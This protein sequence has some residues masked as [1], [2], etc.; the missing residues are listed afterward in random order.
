MRCFW[1]KEGKSFR[2]RSVYE[3]KSYIFRREILDSVCKEAVNPT[4]VTVGVSHC[5]MEHEIIAS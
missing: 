4:P 5:A 3:N 1:S 2:V